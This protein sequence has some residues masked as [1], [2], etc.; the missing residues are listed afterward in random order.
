MSSIRNWLIS[1]TEWRVKEGAAAL[2]AVVALAGCA[3]TN[4]YG[5]M[6]NQA[7]LKGTTTTIIREGPFDEIQAE[8]VRQLRAAGYTRIWTQ[9]SDPQQGFLVLFK[10]QPVKGLLTGDPAAARVILKLS[11][12][13]ESGTRIDL[14]NGSTIVWVKSDVDQD[15]QEVAARLAQK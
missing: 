14:V 4:P 12:S 8:T 5:Q 3:T 9:V 10:M 13:G 7:V 1:A 6:Y 2:L 15:I 11:K